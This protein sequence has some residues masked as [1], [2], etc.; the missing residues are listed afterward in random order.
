M[1]DDF[2]AHNGATRVVPG[3]HLTGT[4][5]AVLADPKASQQGEKLITGRAGTVVVFSSHCFHGGTHNSTA[6]P[7]MGMH[8]YFTRSCH[9]QQVN[10][11]D[12]ISLRTF[13]RLSSTIVGRAALTLLDVHAPDTEQGPKL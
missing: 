12:A 11:Q 9:A 7:R 2:T 5:A 13:R 3:T 4:T 1:L 8:G 10:Q 6:S